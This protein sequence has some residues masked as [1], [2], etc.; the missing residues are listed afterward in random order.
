MA[1]TDL[2][3]SYLSLTSSEEIVFLQKNTVWQGCIQCKHKYP[4]GFYLFLSPAWSG[5]PKTQDFDVLTSVHSHRVPIHRV[6]IL[7]SLPF[8]WRVGVSFESAAPSF[9]GHPSPPI[10]NRQVDERAEARREKGTL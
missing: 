7:P 8:L 10:R 3:R 5:K 1:R 6:L 2:C 4:R 9:P